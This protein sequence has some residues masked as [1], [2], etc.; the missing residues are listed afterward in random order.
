MLAL[1]R[2]LL[3]LIVLVLIVGGV[4]GYSVI[5]RGVSTRVA[6]SW[7][8]TV[9]ARTII[10]DGAVAGHV[11]SYEEDGR[12]EVTYWLGKAYWG[13]GIAT[14]VLAEFLAAVIRTRPIFAR[15]AKDNARSLRVLQKCGFTAVGEETGFANARGKEI[16]EVLLELWGEEKR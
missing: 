11:M 1:I 15:A 13:K 9:L 16:E 8:E 7:V 3:L 5:S 14:R 12:C 6:P 4:M 2:S 10:V